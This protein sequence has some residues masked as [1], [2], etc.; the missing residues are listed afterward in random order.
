[1]SGLRINLRKIEMVR[2]GERGDERELASVLGC[3]IN[4]L[5]I[6]YIVIPSGAK[7]KDTKTWDPIIDMFE[8]R[9]AGWKRNFLSKD[10]RLTLIKN[11]LTNLLIYYLSI[12]TIQASITT[13]ATII[14]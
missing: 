10:G 13:N 14:L 6:K 3:N 2:I 11:T 8:K 12:L 1:M 4:K 7:F 9:L 5:P